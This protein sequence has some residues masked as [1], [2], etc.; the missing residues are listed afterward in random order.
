MKGDLAMQGAAQG[1]AAA[2]GGGSRGA[3]DVV[4]GRR[5][6]EREPSRQAR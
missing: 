3:A 4:H 2:A 1:G 6:A 5:A